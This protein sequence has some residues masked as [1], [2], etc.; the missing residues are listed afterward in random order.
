MVAQKGPFWTNHRAVLD[1]TVG[2]KSLLCRLPVTRRLMQL[3]LLILRPVEPGRI[4][5]HTPAR[6][7]GHRDPAALD[8]VWR[9]E[10]EALLPGV[11][12][13]ALYAEFEVF[14]C[15]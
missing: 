10:E 14:S 4:D 3:A 2:S 9:I 6:Q 12:V 15:I 13:G 7:L 1:R 8:V 11:V 5:L